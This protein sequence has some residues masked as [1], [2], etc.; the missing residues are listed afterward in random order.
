MIQFYNAGA[1]WAENIG[2]LPNQIYQKYPCLVKGLSGSVHCDLNTYT[3]ISPYN[4]LH[5]NNK[6]TGPFIIIYGFEQN[7]VINT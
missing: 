4:T 5:I 2:Y 1:S 6:Y 7:V 3:T